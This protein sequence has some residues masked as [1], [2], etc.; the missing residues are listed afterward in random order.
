MNEEITEGV[1]GEATEGKK[2]FW[3]A[4][5]TAGFGCGLMTISVI[6]VIPVMIGFVLTGFTGDSM[7][8]MNTFLWGL[9]ENG[10]FFALATIAIA[11]VG[12][13]LISLIIKMRHTISITEY[14]GLRPI[15]VKAMLISLVIAA[16]LVALSD[17]LSYVLGKTTVSGWQLNLYVSSGWPILLWAAFI[18]FAPIFEETLFRGFLFEGF[19]HSRIGVAGAVILTAFLWAI[20]HVQYDAYGIIA[21][22]IWGIVFGIV[23]FRTGS[24]WSVLSMHSLMNLVG[25]V[26]T[27]IYAMTK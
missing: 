27:A 20:S 15:S 6:V 2:P 18:V 14:L 13:Y 25:T 5:P 23:R 21:I 4:W 3:G 17:S 9:L 12:T 19:R 24:L 7:E 22:L 8:S 10:L 11:I 1:T 26:E 16:G